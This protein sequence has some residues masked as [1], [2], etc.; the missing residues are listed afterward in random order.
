MD[1]THLNKIVEYL[2]EDTIIHYD[3]TTI[4]LIGSDIEYDIEFLS[5]SNGFFDMMW[6]ILKKDYGLNSNQSLYVYG[7]Y[8]YQIN[9]KIK[10]PGSINES[11][12]N[13]EKYLD[14]IVDYMV[15]DTTITPKEI[16]F[17]FMTKP[18]LRSPYGK[19]E[20][21]PFHFF[22]EVFTQYCSD[23]YGLTENESY[24]VWEKYK[25]ILIGNK[26]I[27]ESV[28]NKEIYLDKISQY[29]I[30]DTELDYEQKLVTYPFIPNINSQWGLSTPLS[31]VQYESPFFIE[32][33]NYCNSM[34]GLTEYEINYVWHQY[35]VI[36]NHKINSKPMN[37]SVDSKKIY[38]DKIVQYIIDDTII[39]YDEGEIKYPYYSNILL[40]HNHQLPFSVHSF[41]AFSI[42]CENM[43]GLNIEEIQYVWKHYRE[44]IVQ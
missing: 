2:L 17:P 15:E 29:I 40:I 16:L 24:S 25:S 10:L 19:P 28:D 44:K 37:E 9:K 8:L 36:F 20:N 41:R 39:D 30:D 31:Y 34:Y 5:D 3:H 14:K 7:N 18:Y 27:N 32:F 35:K 1:K 22:Y 4:Q 11:V 33:S 6:D 26:L 12:D 38:L 42:Y 43:Y 13:K 23:N 21:F